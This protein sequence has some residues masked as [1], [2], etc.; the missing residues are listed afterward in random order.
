MN[1][2]GKK[3]EWN[4]FPVVANVNGTKIYSDKKM[5]GVS[6]SRVTFEDGSWCDVETGFVQNL[7]GGYV[8]F[9][10]QVI[11]GVSTVIKRGPETFSGCDSL[12]VDGLYGANLF[13]E[14]VDGSEIV[15][16]VEGLQ[17]G[18]DNILVAQQGRTVSIKSKD[19]NMGGGSGNI[20]VIGGGNRI[21]IRGGTITTNGG[22]ITTK[23]STD[24]VTVQV[25]RGTS[26]SISDVE[27]DTKIGDVAGNFFCKV[28]M[29][30]TTEVKSAKNVFIQSS[31][32][33][34]VTIGSMDGTLELSNKSSSEITIRRGVAMNP[35]VHVSGTGD[36]SFGGTVFGNMKVVSTSSGHIDFGEGEVASFDYKSSGTGDLAFA[37]TVAQ[38]L[39][40]QLTS[41]GEATIAKSRAENVKLSLSGTGDLTLANCVAGSVEAKLVSSG[42]VKI[43]GGEIGVLGV[44]SSGTGDF[45]FEGEA[46]S[47][48]LRTSSSGNIYVKSCKT[49]PVISERGSGEVT[50]RRHP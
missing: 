31:G 35:N 29:S 14:P 38:G 41:S 7:H 22:T 15:V 49:V 1:W 43:S 39:T 16:I 42:A 4:G 10:D 36:V 28:S 12:S 21:S 11:S 9:G 19:Q 34:N 8:G 47:A 5:T 44:T 27:Q 13:I 48:T 37:G 6:G 30:G 25:P 24:K 40:V 50:V 46:G 17:S 32:T 3:D 33:G 18:V 20:T 26:I 45:R 2:F 23:S